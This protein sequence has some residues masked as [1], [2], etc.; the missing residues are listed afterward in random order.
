[1]TKPRL[2]LALSPDEAASLL[3]TEEAARALGVDA[4]TVT[5][6]F[7]EG[8]L[9]EGRAPTGPIPRMFWRTAVEQLRDRAR[10][11]RFR[12]L[13]LTAIADDRFKRRFWSKV[14]TNGPVPD[15]RPE[16]GGCWLWTRYI[17]P[18][19]YGQ[20]TVRK[21]QFR[22][23]HMVCYALEVGPVPPGMYVCH[24]CDNPPCVRPEHLFL[25]TPTENALDMFSKGRQGARYLGT[26]NAQ[27]R[28]SDEDVRAIRAVA[29]YYGRTA[30]LA[31]KYRVSAP[32]IR[33]VLTGERWGHVA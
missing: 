16:L 31:R 15:G 13:D 5:R 32:T 3:S 9:A 22:T 4:D 21:G 12:G 19:G 6:W 27:S 25:G 1:M 26:E 24:H 29:Y 30:A 14:D 10:T 18:E 17:L 7:R 33:K 2:D 20:F 28:L 23:A 11:R 8:L